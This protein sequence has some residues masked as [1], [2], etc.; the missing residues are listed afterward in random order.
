[1]PVH[2]QSVDPLQV[3]THAPPHPVIL[4]LVFA[5]QVS[6]QS[7][8]FVQSSVHDPPVQSTPQSTPSWHVSAHDVAPVHV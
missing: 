2:V 5:A 4:Q 7:P 1:M 6:A 3:R 8:A